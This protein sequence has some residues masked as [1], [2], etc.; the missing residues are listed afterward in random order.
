MKSGLRMPSRALGDRTASLA[1]VGAY[2][3]RAGDL[4]FDC[5]VSI[6]H[7]DLLSLGNGPARSAR[8]RGA[9]ASGGFAIT[10]T[11]G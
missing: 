1:E 8:G 10:G 4:G 2:L 11:G 6:D 9:A 7:L 3:R 5:P